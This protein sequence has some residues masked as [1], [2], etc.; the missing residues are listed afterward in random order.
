M[1]ARWQ[2]S[3]LVESNLFF[4]EITSLVEVR[5]KYIEDFR[6][7]RGINRIATWEVEAI[8][9]VKYIICRLEAKDT[10]RKTVR[11]FMSQSLWLYIF[12]S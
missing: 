8:D 2:W 6:D 10:V 9:P 12:S 1:K 7:K 5:L 4:S 11:N 3:V